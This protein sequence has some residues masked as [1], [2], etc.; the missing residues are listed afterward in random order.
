[1]NKLI[2]AAGD[3]AIE[4]GDRVRLH[5]ALHLGDALVDA[6]SADFRAVSRAISQIE[7][8]PDRYIG[9]LAT[10]SSALT[11]KAPDDKLLEA[12]KNG[13]LQTREDVEREVVRLL[14]NQKWMTKYLITLKKF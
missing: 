6:S 13:R 7:S 12:A 9:D 2:N 14:E 5:F 11:D 8:D 10:R 4:M 3:K 1:M